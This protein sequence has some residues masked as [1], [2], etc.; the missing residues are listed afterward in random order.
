MRQ[1]MTNLFFRISFVLF[2]F[3]LVIFIG[4]QTQQLHTSGTEGAADQGTIDQ[5]VDHLN[6]VPS[7]TPVNNDTDSLDG[8]LNQV[9]Q[10]LNA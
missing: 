5:Q 6:T 4:C 1:T 7:E 10:D 3:V 8:D 2:L 9:Q